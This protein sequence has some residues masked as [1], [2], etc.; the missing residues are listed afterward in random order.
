MVR[1]SKRDLKVKRQGKKIDISAA[2]LAVSLTRLYVYMM[3]NLYGWV[4]ELEARPSGVLTER[5]IP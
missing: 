3:L 2:Y 4:L 1:Y 5:A